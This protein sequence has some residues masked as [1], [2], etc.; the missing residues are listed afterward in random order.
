MS[1]NNHLL[2]LIKN[3]EVYAPQFL[4]KKDI[5]IA[6]DKIGAIKDKIKIDS[7][8]DIEIIEGNGK[9]LIPGFIDSH[10]HIVG[11]GGE[12]GYQ[13]RTPEIMLIEIIRSGITTVI[14]CLGT[15]GT[16]RTMS[17]LVAKARGL[18]EEGIT[19]YVYTGS[20]QVPVK[21][22]T[23]SIMQDLILIDKIIGVGEIAIS[24][25]RSSQPSVEEIKKIAAEARVG[26]MLSG[27]A[28]VINVHIGDGKSKFSILEDV[29]KNFDIPPKQ[30]V[31][32][33]AERSQ[34]V[35]EAA[36]NYAKKG[37]L[38]DLTTAGV[39]EF[40]GI[41][42]ISCGELLKMLLEQGISI[43]NISFSSD[44]QGSLP[45]FDSAG[46][47]T[48]LEVGKVSTLYDEVRIAVRDVKLP[49]E[50][51]LPVVTKNPAR[52]LKLANKGMIE[53]GKDADLVMLEKNFEINTV[54][55]KGKIMVR[56]A[57]VVVKGTFEN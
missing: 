28:G 30:F 31:A 16:S 6:A 8:L 17:N 54:I 9:I 51:V 43:D 50:T 19:C 37:G 2:K 25:H 44:G 5:L 14:G 24:D 13:T 1:E 52:Y 20:Y 21:T 4:G 3:V 32:T 56:D 23:G 29:I 26:G 49:L 55:A 42:K 53:I 22:L 12:G 15:D 57:Q 33:H 7:N 41:G 47:F 48:G 45:V 27:K 38:I 10:V 11:G 46:G 18:D 40:A 36:I 34:Q 35:F 39:R